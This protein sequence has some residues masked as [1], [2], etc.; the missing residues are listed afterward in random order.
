MILVDTDVLIDSLKDETYATD[1]IQN[2]DL[3]IHITRFTFGSIGSKKMTTP[4]LFLSRDL[5]SRC[6]W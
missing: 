5:Q 6:W 4:S 2:N 1:F 3:D